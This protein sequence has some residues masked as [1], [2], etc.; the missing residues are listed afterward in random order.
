MHEQYA[1]AIA[2]CAIRDC[3]NP[4]RK[5][6]LCDAHHKRLREGRPL[7]TPLQRHV[8][9]SLEDRIAAWSHRSTDGCLLWD[10]DTSSKG[11]AR[12]THEGRKQSVHC[13]TYR[14]AYG[15]EALPPGWEL[16]HFCRIRRCI[17]PMHLRA[18]PK[19]S[20]KRHH[21]ALRERTADG[22]W[23]PHDFIQTL[24]VATSM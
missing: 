9:G 2:S 19:A 13:L 16:D 4:P 12:M 3:T 18:L 6:G 5:L 8:L 24:P 7:E 14:L 22:R 21:S 15:D 17:E 11:Y 1:T 20:H 23:V 10:G